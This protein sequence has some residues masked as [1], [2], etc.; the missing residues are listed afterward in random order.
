M[1][2][3][4]SIAMYHSKYSHATDMSIGVAD[5]FSSCNFNLIEDEEDPTGD[6]SNPTEDEAEAELE[7]IASMKQHVNVQK[8]Y[9][10][11]MKSFQSKHHQGMSSKSE[12]KAADE[13]A[14]YELEHHHSNNNVVVTHAPT[15][16]SKRSTQW[17]AERKQELSFQ[18]NQIVQQQ[19]KAAAFRDKAAQTT[20]KSKGRRLV[21][22]A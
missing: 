10:G 21:G 9:L 11:M 18:K 5:V 12:Q 13:Y 14:A 19:K 4:A 17:Q 16:T 15:K 3:R 8:K 22:F 1:L 7:A 20:A 2:M 6:M